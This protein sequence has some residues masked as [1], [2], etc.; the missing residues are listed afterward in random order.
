MCVYSRSIFVKLD[1]LNIKTMSD[2]IMMREYL[3]SF[4]CYIAKKIIVD[5]CYPA[6]DVRYDYTTAKIEHAFNNVE[7]LAMMPHLES[8]LL[9]LNHILTRNIEEAIH[10]FYMSGYAM[11]GSINLNSMLMNCDTLIITYEFFQ[12]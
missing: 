4:V 2:A 9:G 10:E 5:A 1:K 7:H 8:A 3:E 12:K 6:M 11:T